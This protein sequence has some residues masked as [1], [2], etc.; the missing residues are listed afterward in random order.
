MEGYLATCQ[1]PYEK[2]GKYQKWM[3]KTPRLKDFQGISHLDHLRISKS[4]KVVVTEALG[5]VNFES[6]TK[7]RFSEWIYNMMT[8]KPILSE[9]TFSSSA[10]IP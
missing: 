5:G 8:R 10:P 2:D 3:K 4:P 6:K 1:T 9:T 7:R